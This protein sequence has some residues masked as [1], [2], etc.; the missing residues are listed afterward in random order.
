V[1]RLA[2]SFPVLNGRSA[3]PRQQLE[4]SFPINI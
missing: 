4:G 1:N 3:A 2:T